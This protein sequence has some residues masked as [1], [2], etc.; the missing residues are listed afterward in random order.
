MMTNTKCTLFLKSRNYEK[1]LVPECFYTDTGVANF[2]KTGQAN[3]ENAFCMF[4]YDLMG[5]INFTIGQDYLIEGD[6][7]FT[8]DNT[9]E[10]TKSQSK[11]ELLKLKGIKTIV[12]ADLKKYGAEKMWHYELSCK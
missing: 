7:D 11:G 4:T 2:R 6:V 8:F 5:D 3:V 10:M 9:N 12:K 1:L